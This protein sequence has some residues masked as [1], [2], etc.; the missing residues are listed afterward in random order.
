MACKIQPLVI[1]YEELLDTPM[2][3]IE[4]IS[5]FIGVQAV[6]GAVDTPMPIIR[7]D[8]TYHNFTKRYKLDLIK[9]GLYYE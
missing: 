7:R 1:Y 3:V 2:S 8:A 4:Q 6:A 5:D 9:K